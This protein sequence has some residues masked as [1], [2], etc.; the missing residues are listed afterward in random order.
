MGLKRLIEDQ[1]IIIDDHIRGNR[2]LKNWDDPSVDVHIDKSTN[3]KINGEWQRVRIRVPINSNRP[4]KVENK[5][6][7]L[8]EIPRRLKK[9]I[10]D[11]FS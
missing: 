3:S 5:K 8:E 9:E 4:I 11:A 7:K 2:E 6:G 10:K 1:T